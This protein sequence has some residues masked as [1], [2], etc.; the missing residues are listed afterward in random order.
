MCFMH[1]DIKYFTD[2]WGQAVINHFKDEHTG[3]IGIAGGPYMPSMPGSW[4]AGGLVSEI[5]VPRTSEDIKPSLKN[6]DDKE[7]GKSR[8]VVLDGVWMCVRRSLFEQISFDEAFFSGYHFYDID[9]CLQINALGY[10]LYSVFDILIKHFSAGDMNKLWLNNAMLLQKKWKRQLPVKCVELSFAESC[11][12][13]FKTLNEYLDI[14]LLNDTPK[15]A[16]YK[17]MI[18][19]VLKFRKGYLYYKTPFY[20]AKYFN[21]IAR[22]S[23]K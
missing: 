17:L 10:K 20:F 22:Y 9:I 5:I 4:W 19:E 13:E 6:F 23:S 8:V 21:K 7:P 18:T 16:V 14:L 11:A 1:D 15:S 2:N 3:A 12:I